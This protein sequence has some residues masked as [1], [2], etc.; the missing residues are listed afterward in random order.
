MYKPTNRIAV[1]CI[2]GIQNTFVMK[3]T[4]IMHIYKYFKIG[5]LISDAIK[6]VVQINK[7]F[8]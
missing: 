7:Y 6:T 5:N 2:I 8:G 1:A 4:V 3:D